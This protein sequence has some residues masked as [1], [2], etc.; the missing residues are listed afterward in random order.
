VTTSA[1]TGP[2][3]GSLIVEA[4]TR[5]PTREAFVL[6]D[7]RVTYAETADTTARILRVMH[8]H[9][10]RRGCG[11]GVLSPNAPEVFMTQAAAF[12]SGARYSGL[13]PMGS[14]D[15]HVFLCDDAEIELLVVH[16]K[17]AETAAAIADR[18]ASVRHVLTIGPN[19]G[20]P[21]LLDLVAGIDPGPLQALSVDEEEV[22]WLQY[23]GGTTGTP[24]GAMLSHRA[25]VQEVQSLTAAW[26]LPENPRYLAS[27]PITHAA[28]LPLLP[29]LVRGGT[30]VLQQGFDPEAWLYAIEA[31][32][33]NYTFL[34]PTMLYT[35]LDQTDP[36]SVDTSSLESLVYGAA[37]MSAAR[38]QETQEV[39]GQIVLQVYGQTECV[40]MTTSLRKDEHDPI[41]RPE[42][43]ASCGRPVAGVEVELLDEAGSSVTGGVVGELAVRSRNVMNGYWK[44]PEE[45]ASALR[46]GWL[47]TGDMARRDD[48]GFFYL[49]DRKK[50]MIV[51]GGFNVFAKEV[52][53][54][55]AAHAD[56]SAVAVIG[57]PDDKWGEAVAAFV[58]ARPGTTID[59]AELT[60]SV[61]ARKGP[62]QT[63]KRLEV[64]AD[65][66][67][68]AVGK[69]D[70][71]TLRAWHWAN[72]ARQ[73]N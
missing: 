61:R 14:V 44:R 59:V 13:H 49:V 45:T 9:G 73:V 41:G 43:L 2:N 28:V 7:R 50:D 35:L 3:Y 16:P 64:V 25:L 31:E 5:Y 48:D 18:A 67:M 11:V 57:V 38:I 20:F 40:G 47:H 68:T 70:K 19:D 34:V 1:A 53:D 21:N 6:G 46:D 58:V 62:H 10:L 17:F 52:E 69:I 32:K 27:S 24:K 33:I 12:L 29:T 8:D 36:T 51:T 30:V 15:D 4:L 26:G 37:P 60:A 56:V 42:L 22:G 71:K 55:I 65:L 23:T 63:P 54:A 66:P 39:F 72:Q